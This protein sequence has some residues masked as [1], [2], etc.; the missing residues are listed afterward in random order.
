MQEL[1]PWMCEVRTAFSSR[2]AGV[3]S[4]ALEA[5]EGRGSLHG[6]PCLGLFIGAVGW[7]TKLLQCWPACS[8]SRIQ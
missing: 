4:T 6:A 7:E 1:R 5:G 2:R 3:G 8:V